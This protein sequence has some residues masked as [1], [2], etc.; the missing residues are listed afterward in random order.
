MGNI[1]DGVLKSSSDKILPQINAINNIAFISWRTINIT[2]FPFH[3]IEM[4]AS[5]FKKTN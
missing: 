1:Q 3:L 5:S 4:T 2:P